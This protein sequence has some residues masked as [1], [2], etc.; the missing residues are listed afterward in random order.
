MKQGKMRLRRGTTAAFLSLQNYVFRGPPPYLSKHNKFPLCLPFST[1]PSSTVSSFQPS[2]LSAGLPA[3][4]LQPGR[5]CPSFMPRS[6]ICSSCNAL[7]VYLASPPYPSC[8]RPCARER[9]RAY[10]THTPAP[11]LSSRAEPWS[12]IV[13][14]RRTRPD[15]GANYPNRM[16][17]RRQRGIIPRPGKTTPTGVVTP[18]DAR[19]S[20]RDAL[21][22]RS[23]AARILDNDTTNARTKREIPLLKPSRDKRG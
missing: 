14:L 8:V 17:V 1:S 20:H 22:D 4:G 6:Y 2:L 5:V 21:A 12:S 11:R 19:F 13:F 18:L 3:T 7:L 23:I 10:T 9:A 15:I 16:S